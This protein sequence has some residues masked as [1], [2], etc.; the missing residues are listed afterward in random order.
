MMT[1]EHDEEKSKYHLE[2][3]PLSYTLEVD[4]VRLEIAALEKEYMK[5]DNLFKLRNDLPLV[6]ELLMDRF[7]QCHQRVCELNDMKNKQ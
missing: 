3:L 7:K 2:L 4:K 6:K 5:L 1:K